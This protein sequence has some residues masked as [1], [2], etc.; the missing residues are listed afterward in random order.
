ME[1]ASAASFAFVVLAV[2]STFAIMRSDQLVRSAIVPLRRMGLA[3]L[4]QSAHEAEHGGGGHGEGLRIVL[5]GFFRSASALLSEIERNNPLLISQIGVVD[6]NPVVYNALNTRGVQVTYGD[7]SNLD[8]LV[9]AGVSHAE[10]IVLSIPDSLLKGA[11]NEKL[12]R[13]IRSIN[14]TAKIVATAEVLSEVSNLYAAGADYVVVPRL[15]EA[16]ELYSVIEAAQAGLLDN[17]RADT[18]ARL[19]ERREVLP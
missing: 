5:L 11:T 18:D 2:L 8:T 13:H 14:G 6:F 4:G 12:V 3:D 16:R 7:I 19:S 1:T 15:S 17:K 10:L 9:H